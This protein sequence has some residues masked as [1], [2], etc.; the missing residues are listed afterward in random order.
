MNRTNREQ[1]VQSALHF[2]AANSRLLVFLLLFLSGTF[3]GSMIFAASH[4]ALIKD[5]SV[6]LEVQAIT[7]GFKGG[8][9]ALFSSC[10]STILLLAVL[11]L[12]G[13]SACG[14][15][16]TAIV[17]FFFGLGLGLTEAYYYG[18]GGAGIAFVALLVIP[19]ALMAA[20]ALLMGC[21][22]TLRMSLLLSNQLLPTSAHCGNLWPD[23][24]LYCARFLIFIGIA[25]GAGVLD[26]CLRVVF[27]KLFIAT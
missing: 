3:L 19:H 2:L 18:I 14:A 12:S 23:F 24:K 22:E 4:E 5:L 20:I 17:P 21:A 15:P 8:V 13:L 27:Q 25:F 6:I 9:G 11:F 1:A 10:L 16:V 26:V 7:G